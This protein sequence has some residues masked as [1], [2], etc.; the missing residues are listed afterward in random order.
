MASG[1]AADFWQAPTPTPTKKQG[2]F[3][4]NVYIIVPSATQNPLIVLPLRRPRPAPTTATATTAATTAPGKKGGGCQ[5][6]RVVA[7]NNRAHPGDRGNI[8]ERCDN[9]EGCQVKTLDSEC[10]RWYIVVV[11]VYIIPRLSCFLFCRCWLT[12]P[13][14]KGLTAAGGGSS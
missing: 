12:P 13:P 11:K 6:N 7:K 4:S 9:L 3:R 10:K 5:T 8:R 14:F 2:A 1:A